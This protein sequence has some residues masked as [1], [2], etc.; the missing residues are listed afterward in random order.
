ME[1]IINCQLCNNVYDNPRML[2]CQH[3]FCTSCLQGRFS[4]ARTET[5][6]PVKDITCPTCDKFVKLPRDGPEGLPE[7]LYILQVL[8]TVQKAE[9]Q[10]GAKTYEVGH[11]FHKQRSQSMLVQNETQERV[12]KRRAGS[13]DAMGFPQIKGLHESNRYEV[14]DEEESHDGR[15]T[16]PC[17][18]TRSVCPTHADTNSKLDYIC[19]SCSRTLCII[20]IQHEICMGHDIRGL[21]DLTTDLYSDNDSR[22]Q[23]STYTVSSYYPIPT[24]PYSAV[25]YEGEDLD[26]PLRCMSV[27]GKVYESSSAACVLHGGKLT[28]F[29]YP[30]EKLAC[31][32][33]LNTGCIHHDI[34]PL[35]EV[36][37]G[38]E[39][40]QSDERTCAAFEKEEVRIR[41]H[42]AMMIEEVRQIAV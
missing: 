13:I 10:N 30:C 38:Q 18:P 9:D 32:E 4:L 33:C 19:L 36:E 2:P 23:G 15:R 7:S 17:R 21:G 31:V 40:L 1:G 6:S 14:L 22:V 24:A 16:L 26:C 41:R 37:E 3:S 29:C 12:E 11:V 5:R 42:A 39:A 27:D 8:E 20:C 35:V 28:Y 34:E 25:D